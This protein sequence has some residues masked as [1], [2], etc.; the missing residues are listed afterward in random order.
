MLDDRAAALRAIV[1]SAPDIYPGFYSF[2]TPAKEAKRS[3]L[4]QAMSALHR[5]VGSTL[6]DRSVA[7]LLKHND[8]DLERALLAAQDGTCNRIGTGLALGLFRRTRRRAG[9]DPLPFTGQ[10]GP[11]MVRERPETKSAPAWP[12]VAP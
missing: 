9:T 4:E 6:F 8:P 2:P 11:A 10:R 7:G 5:T 3:L 12:S 1:G